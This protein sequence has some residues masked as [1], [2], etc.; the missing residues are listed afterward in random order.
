MLPTRTSDVATDS[1]E[2]LA[3]AVAMAMVIDTELDPS[4]IDALDRLDAFGRLG[5][6]RARFMDVARDFCVGLRERIGAADRMVMADVS[7]IDE[8]LAGVRAPDKRLLVAQLVAGV[9]AAD[10]R[11]KDIERMAYDHLL[12]R[13]G[14]TR[15]DVSQAIL[16]AESLRQRQAA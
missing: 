6:G 12:L 1:P 4:E 16:A 7:L 9:I 8:C 5:L 11:V 3:R 2:A 15:R 14:L 10:G 13:W